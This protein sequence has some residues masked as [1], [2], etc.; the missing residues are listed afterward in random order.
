MREKR[1]YVSACHFHVSSWRS[2]LFINILRKPS[3][4]SADS[5]SLPF[6]YIFRYDIIFRLFHNL[7]RIFLSLIRKYMEKF[8]DRSIHISSPLDQEPNK[9]VFMRSGRGREE[10]TQKRHRNT[11]FI[12]FLCWIMCTFL[13]IEVSLERLPLPW[14]IVTRDYIVDG[15]YFKIGCHKGSRW[16]GRKKSSCE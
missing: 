3:F 9:N 12:K 4:P 15:L 8:I 2:A 5:C 7:C 16:V 6:F 11:F 1:T 10:I 14:I 13:S